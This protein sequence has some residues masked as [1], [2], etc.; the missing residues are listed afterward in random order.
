MSK[1]GT[2]NYMAPELYKNEKGNKTVDI[3]SL[4]IMLYRFFNYNRLPFLPDYPNDITLESREEALYK[5]VSGEKMKA[6]QN[7]TRDVAEIILKMCNYYPKDRYQSAIDLRKD[8]DIIYKEIKEPRLLFDLNEKQM[9][10]I[11][12]ES[13]KVDI[14]EQTLSIFNNTESEEN[15]EIYYF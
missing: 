12:N 5:R 14:H 10:K 2:E 15:K 13:E 9:N 11:Y 6:P 7:A 8:L 4:G 3:Y 1:K